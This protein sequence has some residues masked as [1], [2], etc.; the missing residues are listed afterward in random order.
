MLH[1]ALEEYRHMTNT[2]PG[3]GRGCKIIVK[4]SNAGFFSEA[5]KNE[6]EGSYSFRSKY[7]LRK[8]PGFDIDTVIL[9]PVS[10]V[11]RYM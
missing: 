3:K 5:A 8:L 10:N 11:L 6:Y 9:Y 1:L 7:F 2:V 4:D